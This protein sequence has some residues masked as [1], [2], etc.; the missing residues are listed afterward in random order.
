M[1]VIHFI[2]SNWGDSH[3]MTR[4]IDIEKKGFKVCRHAYQRDYYPSGYD[5]I[6]KHIIG[7]LK[8]GIY[9][10]R[11]PT[12][13]EAFIYFLRM[14]RE[15]NAI[16]YIFGLDN[17]ILFYL[18]CILNFSKKN[19]IYEVDDVRD[20]VSQNNIIS[21]LFLKIE[22][23]LIKKSNLV[24]TT[25]EAFMD[26]FYFKEGKFNIPYL[27]ME[28]KV[29]PNIH[30]TGNNSFPLISTYNNSKIKL[31]YFGLIRCPRSIEIL[32]NL[33]RSYEHIEVLIRGYFMPNCKHLEEEI[34]KTKNINYFGTYVSPHDLKSIYSE[35][36][37]SWIC[38]PFG[39]EGQNN[40][41]WAKTNRFYEAG[42]FKKP[43]IAAKGTKDAERVKE[44][45]VGIVLNLADIT[46][47]VQEIGEIIKNKIFYMQQ[48]YSI[49]D[50]NKFQITNDY[51]ILAQ[52][53]NEI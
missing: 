51:D 18:S 14:K 24:I 27:L 45:G 21:R 41:K 6:H 8:N 17:Y 10:N 9:T 22:C 16:Y 48:N 50:I 47:S 37:I 4:T 32:L 11:I 7:K 30:E 44:Y 5:S 28:N 53:I 13:F 43:M 2:L 19:V 38:Y 42:Y 36:D 33:V 3:Q 46:Q 25:S 35:I 15:S 12:Y 20:L 49:I 1:K 40:W 34:F 39:F 26:E 29:H 52:K 31:G 23:F